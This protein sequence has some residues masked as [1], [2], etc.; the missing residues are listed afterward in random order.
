MWPLRD[1]CGQL[2]TLPA[3]KVGSW[4]GWR[5][6]FCP[7]GCEAADLGRTLRKRN[8]ALQQRS[9]TSRQF[10]CQDMAIAVA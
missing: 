6:A 10:E 7:C 4:Q 9:H 2:Q 8:G 5:R 3:G 1:R